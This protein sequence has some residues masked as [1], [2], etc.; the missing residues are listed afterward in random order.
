MLMSHYKWISAKAASNGVLLLVVNFIQLK[1]ISLQSNDAFEGN[2]K[3]KKL[4]KNSIIK[5]YCEI[6]KKYYI[7]FIFR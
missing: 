7:F 6:G 4:T 2:N 1:C 3:T 5:L